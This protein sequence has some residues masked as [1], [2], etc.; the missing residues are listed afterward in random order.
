MKNRMKSG[1]YAIKHM[2]TGRMYIGQSQNIASRFSVH[3]ATLRAGKHHCSYLQRVWTKY[4]EHEFKLYVIQLVPIP[5]LDALEKYWFSVY[6]DRL[7]NTKPPGNSCRGFKFSADTIVKMRRSAKLASNT[8]EQRKLRSERAK[9]QH[10]TGNLRRAIVNPVKVCNL[11]G[12]EFNR[13]SMLPRGY[14]QGPRCVFCMAETAKIQGG[15]FKL[16]RFDID[17]DTWDMAAYLLTP[18]RE[19]ERTLFDGRKPKQLYRSQA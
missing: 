19:Y 16:D 4:G 13:Y 17:Q 14:H 6:A 2:P 11:C 8:P 3:L 9:R 5:K 10:A 1:I 12:Q 7:L 18:L 15:S